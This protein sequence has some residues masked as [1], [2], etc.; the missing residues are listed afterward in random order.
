MVVDIK[1]RRDCGWV[2]LARPIGILAA[3]HFF[4]VAASL[5]WLACSSSSFDALNDLTP[6]SHIT[7][8]PERTT[9]QANVQEAH[10]WR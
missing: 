9:H 8:Q 1:D 10:V 6:I 5:V 7:D 4:R 3:T 2:I